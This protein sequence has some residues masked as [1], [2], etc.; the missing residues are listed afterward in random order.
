[1]YVKHHA[2]YNFLKNIS[3]DEPLL[4]LLNDIT[5]K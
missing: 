2:V 4:Y 5:P 3:I 1:M